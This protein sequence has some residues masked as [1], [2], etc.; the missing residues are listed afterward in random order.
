M[1]CHVMSCHERGS[2][3]HQKNSD[4]ILVL[5]RS[6]CQNTNDRF[7][8]M[9][10]SQHRME[11]A[12]HNYCIIHNIMRKDDIVWLEAILYINIIK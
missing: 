10:L 6:L 4:I 2:Q 3:S 9:K 12:P 7:Y 5:A 11:L 8:K 1:S